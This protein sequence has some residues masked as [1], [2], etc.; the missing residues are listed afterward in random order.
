MFRGVRRPGQAWLESDT[1]LAAALTLYEASLCPDCGHPL[2]ETLDPS[3]D[4]DDPHGSHKWHVPPPV[5][6]FS[7]TSIE[8]AAGKYQESSQPRALRFRSEKVERSRRGIPGA[9]RA[10]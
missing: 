9:S 8:R 10:R 2:E 7:C 4:V 5:R 6:C 1:I 3:T